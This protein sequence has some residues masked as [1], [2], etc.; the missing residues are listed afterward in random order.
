MIMTALAEKE[1]RTYKEIQ[2]FYNNRFNNNNYNQNPNFPYNS[3]NNNNR[4][5]F[6]RNNNNEKLCNICSRIGHY[7][8]QYRLRKVQ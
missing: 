8:L 4:N 2:T 5:N 6:L 7:A 3:K 1:I